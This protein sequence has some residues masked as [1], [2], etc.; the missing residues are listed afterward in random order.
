MFYKGQKQLNTGRTWWRKGHSPW[1]KG[2][3]ISLRPKTGWSIICTVCGKSKYYQLNE[4]KKRFRKYCSPA[5]YHLD[6]QKENLSYSGLHS[7]I[8]RQLGNASQCKIC[9][10]T[11]TVDWANKSREYKKDITDWIPLCR[12]HHIAYDKNRLFISLSR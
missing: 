11:K 12:K 5:C 6:S 7:W 3:N 1:N 4:H 8:K 10:S 2:T 9:E